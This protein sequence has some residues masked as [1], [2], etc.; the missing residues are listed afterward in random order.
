M[1]YEERRVT[2]TEDGEPR[3]SELSGGGHHSWA[4]AYRESELLDW[5]FA[6]RRR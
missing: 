3:Y 1:D 4:P 6:Q 2:V 5:L